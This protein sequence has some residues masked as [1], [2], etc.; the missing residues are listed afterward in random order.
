MFTRIVVG[1]DGFDGGADALALADGLAG[2][3]TRIVAV[4]AFP[5]ETR[6]SRG[7]VGGYEELMR[8]D[9]LQMLRRVTEAGTAMELRAIPDVSPARALHRESERQNADL[10]VVGSC[11]NGPV[12]RVLLGDVSR[13]VMHG[14]PCSVAIAPRGFREQPPA[15]HVV[16]VG[17]DGGPE[18]KAAMEFATELAKAYEADLRILAAVPGP[19]AVAIGYSATFSWTE[20]AASQC[21]A[22]RR[23]LDELIPEL[24]LDATGTVV[25]GLPSECLE[26]LSREVDVLVVGSRGWG[27]ARRVLLGSTSDRLA[28]HAH[29]PLVVVRSPVHEPVHGQTNEVAHT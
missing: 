4:N 21:K 29:C 15:I 24:D 6:P 22:A 5:Y 14:A 19:S 16:G 20:L 12:G 11:R 25:E 7:S 8:E 9:A 18:A 17:Y 23:E 13:S 3:E 28:H 2:P 1:I 26:K 10:L 27:A